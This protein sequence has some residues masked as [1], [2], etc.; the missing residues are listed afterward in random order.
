[1]KLVRR[2]IW[3]VLILAVA[4]GVGLFLRPVAY[5][6]GSMYLREA[7]TG[8]HNREVSTDG[9]RVHYL[10][11]GPERGNPVVLVHGLGGRAEDW[12]NLAPALAAAGYRVYMPDLPGFGRSERP[13]S[14][15]YSV[16]DQ[17]R[18]VVD[19]MNAMHLARVDL[20][21]WS[22]GGWIVQLVAAQDPDRVHRLMLF[23]SA[24]LHFEPL[25]DTR[26]F[27]PDDA[28]QVAQ[29]DAL[30]MPNPP[31]VPGFVANDILRVSRQQGW[32]VQRAMASML[33]GQGTTDTLLPTL[34]MPVLI[35]WGDLDHITP[36]AQGRQMLKL[37]PHAEL[38]VV[39]GCGHLAP[40]ECSAEIAPRVLE[41][42][43]R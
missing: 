11:A 14:F 21:G 31:K 35:V 26:L 24:G 3:V 36:L 42:I 1:M 13:A 33:T 17:A 20:G 38:D 7:L 18:I 43:N 25:W 37:I 32:I 27:T 34:Q 10:V 22:M 5:F 39:P 9:I 29:L 16:N 23:D 19:F 30:L 6:N 8:V 41:F 15:S 12:R 40:L 2:I 28:D 4:A